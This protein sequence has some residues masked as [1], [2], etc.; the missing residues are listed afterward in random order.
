MRTPKYEELH[1]DLIKQSMLIR[2]RKVEVYV[3]W[4]ADIRTQVAFT[5]GHRWPN[6]LLTA[7][8]WST[9]LRKL[10]KRLQM[11]DMDKYRGIPF[12]Q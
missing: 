2:M 5:A 10:D 3:V 7:R 9:L 4:R 12:P 8:K 6:P 1:R 11:P